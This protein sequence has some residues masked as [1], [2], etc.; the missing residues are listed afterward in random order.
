MPNIAKILK[1]EI[2]RLARREIRAHLEGTRKSVAQHQRE[3][4]NLK[5]RVKTLERRVS[6]LERKAARPE[7]APAVEAAAKQARFVPKGLVSMRKRLGLSAADLAG[8][9]GVTAQTIYNWEGGTTKPRPEQ[10]SKLVSL[11][12]VGKRAIRAHMDSQQA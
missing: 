12:S 10:Q 11:R 9:M 4:S 7:A 5:V 8:L 2:S 3:I 6:T 1:E